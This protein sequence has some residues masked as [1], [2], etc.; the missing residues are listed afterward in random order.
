MP[1]SWILPA[2]A[3]SAKIRSTQLVNNVGSPWCHLSLLSQKAPAL[4]NCT[5]PTHAQQLHVLI[6]FLPVLSPAPSWCW[7]LGYCLQRPSFLPL[8]CSALLLRHSTFSH[9][10]A[11]CDRSSAVEQFKVSSC[12]NWGLVW[13]FCYSSLASSCR[14]PWENTWLSSWE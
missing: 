13:F 10:L 1:V 8:I 11:D 3:Y 2:V 5:Y 7:E 6:K 14:S 4:K 12:F 9:L